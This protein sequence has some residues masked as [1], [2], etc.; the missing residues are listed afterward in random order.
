[1]AT[2]QVR[3]LAPGK[4]GRHRKVRYQIDNYQ[5]GCLLSESA[6]DDVDVLLVHVDG[7]ARRDVVRSNRKRDEAWLEPDGRVEL[8]SYDIS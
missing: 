1:L 5:R 4:S 3:L 8:P 7:D 6:E 2:D